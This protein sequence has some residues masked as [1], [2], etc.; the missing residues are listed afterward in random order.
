MHQTSQRARQWTRCGEEANT[1]TTN[2]QGVNREDQCICVQCIHHCIFRP[3]FGKV[4]SVIL[5]L[6]LC[7]ESQ[8]NFKGPK[9]SFFVVSSG[10]G[11]QYQQWSISFLLFPLPHTHGHLHRPVTL[12]HHWIFVVAA[13]DS[14]RPGRSPPWAQPRQVMTSHDKQKMLFFIVSTCTSPLFCVF[15][16]RSFRS[17]GPKRLSKMCD[18][19][20]LETELSK[21]GE[22]TKS[23]LFRRSSCKW[24][25]SR[26]KYQGHITPFAREEVGGSS[27]Q[28]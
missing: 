22:I 20:I 2:G 1:G 7:L 28:I 13:S 5:M 10:L 11:N 23:L 24:G 16:L 19:G 4:R 18:P 25:V 17:S 21:D 3:Q 9:D 14:S 6:S 15:M 12:P 8:Q 26:L 27:A